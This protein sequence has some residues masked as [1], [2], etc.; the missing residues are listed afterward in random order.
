MFEYNFAHIIDKPFESMSGF[1][2]VLP[3][4]FSGYRW[5]ALKRNKNSGKSILD[6]YLKTV[7]DPN[8]KFESIEEANMY[9]AEDRILCLQ[10]FTN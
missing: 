10:I 4:A 3:G 5:E 7:I 8:H 1:I 6:A 2:N 9:L